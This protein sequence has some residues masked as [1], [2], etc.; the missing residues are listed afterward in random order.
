MALSILDPM[1]LLFCE[2][3]CAT[4]QTTKTFGNFFYFFPRGSLR[5]MVFLFYLVLALKEK[6][7]AQGQ[8]FCWQILNKQIFSGGTICTAQWV[9]WCKYSHSSQLQAANMMSLSEELGSDAHDQL[10]PARTRW[11]EHTTAYDCQTELV[12][13]INLMMDLVKKCTNSRQLHADKLWVWHS[14]G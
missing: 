11:V 9:L 8:L 14:S 2:W 10:P 13:L 3:S 1:S 6:K 12:K 5:K 4:I 7:K